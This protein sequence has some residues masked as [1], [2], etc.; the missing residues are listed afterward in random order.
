[1]SIFTKF[2]KCISQ[3]FFFH[4]Q[5]FFRL[6]LVALYGVLDIVNATEFCALSL[7]KKNQIEKAELLRQKISNV[8]FK[9]IHFKIRS[10]LTFEQR[11]TLK[12]LS[13]STENKVY[14]NNKDTGFVILYNKDAI[15]KIEEQIEDL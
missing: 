12:Q 9:K 8:I 1:M 5:I 11:A 15:Q 3:V 13:Q 14:S 4:P 6:I 2:T 10:N 7:E